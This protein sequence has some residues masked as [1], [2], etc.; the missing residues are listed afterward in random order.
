MAST[1]GIVNTADQRDRRHPVTMV[2]RIIALNVKTGVD[3]LSEGMHLFFRR[4]LGAESNVADVM[5]GLR[6]FVLVGG[7][8]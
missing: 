1:T 2:H 8:L 7:H 4:D 6:K 3:S 5:V